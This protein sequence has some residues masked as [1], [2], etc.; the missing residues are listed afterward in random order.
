MNRDLPPVIR[1]S[2]VFPEA[3]AQRPKIAAFRD[4]MLGQAAGAAEAA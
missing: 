4:W 1:Y 3:W 2:I